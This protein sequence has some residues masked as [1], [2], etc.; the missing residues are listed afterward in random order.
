ME[1]GIKKLNQQSMKIKIGA[2]LILVLV[3]SLVISI[4]HIFNITE[5]FITVNK[6]LVETRLKLFNTHLE[7]IDFVESQKIKIALADDEDKK[8]IEDQLLR[9]IKNRY[10]EVEYSYDKGV[11]TEINFT[12]LDISCDTYKKIALSVN[13]SILPNAKYINTNCV[14]VKE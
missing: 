11:L 4:W 3:T 1:L 7:K 14:E 10:A 5:Q 6:E 12:N 2:F 9:D 13:K 8:E